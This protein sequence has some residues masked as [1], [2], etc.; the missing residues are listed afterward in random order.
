[1]VITADHGELF[2]EW[3]LFGH[4]A[5]LPVGPLLR[6]PWARAAASDE[7]THDPSE[8]DR[9]EDALSVDDR[10]TALGYR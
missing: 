2:G 6:V 5:E 1:M 7:R 3:G 9:T 4:M 10:L 8:Y